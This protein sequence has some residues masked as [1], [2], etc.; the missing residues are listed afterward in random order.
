MPVKHHDEAMGGNENTARCGLPCGSG[1]RVCNCRCA[2]ASGKKSAAA[3]FKA[4]LGLCDTLKSPE[5]RTAH[6]NAAPNH[7]AGQE[8]H[9]PSGRGSQQ[10]APIG[11]DP[12][13]FE[14]F[15]GKF[16]QGEY[17]RGFGSRFRRMESRCAAGWCPDAA[18][19]C[20]RQDQHARMEVTRSNSSPGASRPAAQH[21][22]AVSTDQGPRPIPCTLGLV[23]A[24]SIRAGPCIRLAGQSRPGAPLRGYGSMLMCCSSCASHPAASNHSYTNEQPIWRQERHVSRRKRRPDKSINVSNFH[25]QGAPDEP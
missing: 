23:I 24:K 22:P 11:S 1:K 5:R 19:D 12:A 7:Q 6:G 10:Q 2:R 25:H 3:Y 9:T 16:S 4:T 17:S 18:Q 21:L 13:G 8:F 14:D 15:T 20:R